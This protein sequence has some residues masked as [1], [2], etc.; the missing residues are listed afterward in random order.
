MNRLCKMFICSKNTS[1]IVQ[2][3]E[4]NCNMHVVPCLPLVAGVKK[5]D[6]SLLTFSQNPQAGNKDPNQNLEDPLAPQCVPKTTTEY[7]V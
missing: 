2:V 6:Q 4:L 1:E 3:V 7:T 5:F